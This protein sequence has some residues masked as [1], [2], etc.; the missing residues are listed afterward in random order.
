MVLA[1][2]AV[3]ATLN[4]QGFLT[5]KVTGAPLSSTVSVSFQ[6]WDAL[7]AGNLI[8]AESQSVTVANGS[9]N[10]QIGTGSVQAPPNVAFT[11]VAFDKPYWLEVTVGTDTLAP[12]QPLASSPTAL[13]A[14]VADNAASLSGS[15]AGSQVTG[16]LSNATVPGTAQW[17]ATSA[18]T[19]QAAGNTA[20]IVTGTVP[21]TIT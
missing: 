2:A 1:H 8:Y 16:A 4:Y 11:G 18:A 15:I 20:Y 6:L 12:R 10:V 5:D 9:F 14:A 17:V 3:P 21:T 7:T 13:R 19:Q